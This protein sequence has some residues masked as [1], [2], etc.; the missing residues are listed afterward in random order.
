MRLIILSAALLSAA[1]AQAQRLDTTRMSCDQARATVARA[2]AV[3]LNSGPH[4]YDRYVSDR[5]FCS[6]G[7]VTELAFAPTRDTAMCPV[8][9]LCKTP[10]SRRVFDD[11]N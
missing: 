11:L 8:G 2:G 9:D 5:R 3:V 7:D 1:S 10:G 6:F 4:I